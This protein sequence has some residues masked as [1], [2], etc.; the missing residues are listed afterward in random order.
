MI[1]TGKDTQETLT[2]DKCSHKVRVSARV[3]AAVFAITDIALM[4]DKLFVETRSGCCIGLTVLVRAS[5]VRWNV[6]KCKARDDTT[7]LLVDG[8]T[9]ESEPACDLIFVSAV[10]LQKIIERPAGRQPGL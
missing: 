4:A 8:V 2:L 9:G 7:L 6:H 5:R 1:V 3:L 10:V